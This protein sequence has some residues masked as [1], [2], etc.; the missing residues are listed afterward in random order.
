MKIYWYNNYIT[1]KDYSKNNALDINEANDEILKM[2]NVDE[3]KLYNNLIWSI[4]KYKFI[5]YLNIY[6][7][8]KS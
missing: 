1:K 6:L 7:F 4:I 5:K 2:M 8:I 3:K